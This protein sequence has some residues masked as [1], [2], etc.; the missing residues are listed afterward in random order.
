MAYPSESFDSNTKYFE[1]SNSID[2]VEEDIFPC[3]PATGDVM[4]SA[5]VFNP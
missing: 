1:E 4:Y 2:I 3:V 5:F